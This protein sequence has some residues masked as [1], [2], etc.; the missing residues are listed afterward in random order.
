MSQEEPNLLDQVRK[1]VMGGGWGDNTMSID[2]DIAL[3]R[4]SSITWSETP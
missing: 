2:I 3:L 4:P 1:L